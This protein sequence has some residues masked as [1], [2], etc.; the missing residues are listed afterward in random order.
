MK[1]Y[2]IIILLAIITG[3]LFA[4]F[5][6]SKNNTEDVIVN[7]EVVKVYLFQIG[8]F[9]NLN[10]AEVL[11]TQ[12]SSSIIVN[13]KDLYWVYTAIYNDEKLIEKYKKYLN[14]KN[15]SYYIKEDY[16]GKNDY[17][18]MRKYENVV[19]KSTNNEVISKTNQLILDLYLSYK[20]KNIT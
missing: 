4:I 6:F 9:K 8:V 17:L 3:G 10:N 19:E 5:I 14:E 13:E 15:I 1:K 20:N 11:S 12:H 2:L 7:T 18:K 16:I